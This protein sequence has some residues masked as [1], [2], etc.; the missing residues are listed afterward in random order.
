[1]S[2]FG[3]CVRISFHRSIQ[4]SLSLALA[5]RRKVNS[6]QTN[7]SLSVIV[8]HDEVHRTEES[9]ARS[10]ASTGLILL[11]III[12]RLC[13]NNISAWFQTSGVGYR[14]VVRDKFISTAH[15]ADAGKSARFTIHKNR[16][17]APLLDDS[18]GGYGDRRFLSTLKQSGQ[19]ERG[20]V[21]LS[22]AK[23]IF[24]PILPPQCSHYLSFGPTRSVQCRRQ[25]RRRLATS[26]F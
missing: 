9:T 12:I 14:C 17:S 21:S 25:L 15:W 7:G 8:L 2:E 6:R 1:M 16:E 13:S 26:P 3:D 5:N 19:H 18:G 4:L 10:Q 24:L 20:S 22:Y 11:H 23:T